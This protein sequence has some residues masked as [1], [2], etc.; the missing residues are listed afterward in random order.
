MIN[1]CNKYCQLL[2][3]KYAKISEI[4]GCILK[5]SK[6]SASW[7]NNSAAF[8]KVWVPCAW[9]KNCL[10]TQKG[11]E[12]LYSSTASKVIPKPPCPIIFRGR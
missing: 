5:L 10:I 2:W 12:G 7:A 1:Y 9:G 4:C 6:H 11:F 8:D 3:V